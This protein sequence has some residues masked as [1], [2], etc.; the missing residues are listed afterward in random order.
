MSGW[1]ATGDLPL[2][3]DDAH[4]HFFPFLEWRFVSPVSYWD[5]NYYGK[6]I[7]LVEAVSVI[8]AAIYLFSR[9]RPLRRWGVAIMGIY[10]GYWYFVYLAWM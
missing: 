10:L 6:W 2:H 1:P 8:G 7:G 4:R 9:H 3:H 5:P